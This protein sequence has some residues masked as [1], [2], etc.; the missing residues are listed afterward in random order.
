MP[1]LK[2]TDVTYYGEPGGYI[3]SMIP[4][5]AL[6]EEFWRD[7]KNR[8]RD[9]ALYTVLTKPGLLC[10]DP[11]E[12]IAFSG[13]Q[14][15][16][17]SSEGWQT[18]LNNS[19]LAITGRLMGWKLCSMEI[20]SSEYHLSFYNVERHA[21]QDVLLHR[22]NGADGAVAVSADDEENDEDGNML[23]NLIVRHLGDREAAITRSR[24]GDAIVEER[25]LQNSGPLRKIIL[26]GD[27]EKIVTEH[28]VLAWV[29]DE[30]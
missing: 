21:A 3:I 16:D 23:G 1:V 14:N 28:G 5:V 24:D 8:L 10:D 22:G 29:E 9:F 2:M 17:I 30:K 27:G 4:G 6:D 26:N 25:N 18:L 20:Y 15:D 19:R 7:K 12:P 13:Y 11:V